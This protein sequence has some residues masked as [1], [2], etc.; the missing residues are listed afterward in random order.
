MTRTPEC[1]IHPS[2][3]GLEPKLSCLKYWLEWY[4]SAS[5]LDD[6]AKSLDVEEV[7][8]LS[9]WHWADIYQLCENLKETSA[10]KV[11]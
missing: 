3:E 1:P 2:P 4:L 11:S 9:F 5:V 6:R 10:N 8:S 7:E